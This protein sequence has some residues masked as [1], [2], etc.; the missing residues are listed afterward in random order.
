MTSPKSSTVLPNTELPTSDTKFCISHFSFSI[1][2]DLEQKQFT[3]Q[4]IILALC[5]QKKNL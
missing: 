1:M 3:K 5:F 4:R 2:K